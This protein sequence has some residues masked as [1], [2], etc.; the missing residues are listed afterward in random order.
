MSAR[1]LDDTEG[2]LKA[3]QSARNTTS[4]VRTSHVLEF[5]ISLKPKFPVLSLFVYTFH[6]LSFLPSHHLS[7]LLISPHQ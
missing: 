5:L 2:T 3:E 6:T 4:S 1:V 7:L